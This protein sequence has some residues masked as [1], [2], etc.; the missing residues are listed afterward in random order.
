MVT[1]AKIEETPAREVAMSHSRFNLSFDMIGEHQNKRLYVTEIVLSLMFA[2]IFFRRERSDDP[3]IG[4]AVRGLRLRSF[5][6]WLG[7]LMDWT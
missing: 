2:D 1:L 3:E 5:N 7:V 6:V 4:S